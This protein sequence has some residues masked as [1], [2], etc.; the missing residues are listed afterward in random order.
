MIYA[1]KVKIAILIT[2]YNRKEITLN[3]L[4]R[5]L[6]QE[7]LNELFE[8][9]VFLVD[10]ASTDGTS[11]AVRLAFPNVQIIEGNGTLYWNRG[12]FTAWKAAISKFDFDYYVWLNDDT[13]L[14]PYAIKELIACVK[15]YQKPTIVCG[16][17]SAFGTNTFT[18][19][20]ATRQGIPVVPNGEIQDI[21]IVNGNCV[22]V[23]RSAVKKIG[24]LDPVFPHAI[25]D[26]DYGLRLLKRGGFVVTTRV[27]IGHCERNAELPKWCYKEIPLKKRWSI[28]Y[29][30]L[31]KSHPIYQF[32]YERRHFGLLRALKHFASI[33]LRV[34]IPSLWKVH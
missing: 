15:D 31:G 4:S 13:I 7:Q 30:P 33:H 32:K 24:I 27:F 26:H 8:M 2:C 10:D 18:Y 1:K 21:V 11:E 20:G 23:N 14:F 28:L 17:V 12:M 19:G 9:E 22:L 16:A 29:S 6:E 3:C 5:L 34:L 25:G